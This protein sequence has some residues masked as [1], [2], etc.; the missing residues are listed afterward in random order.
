MSKIRLLDA[1]ASVTPVERGQKWLPDAGA[2]F[3]LM[4]RNA[5]V[6][7]GAEIGLNASA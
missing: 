1:S 6:E 4:L 7:K 2:P 5:G 3:A